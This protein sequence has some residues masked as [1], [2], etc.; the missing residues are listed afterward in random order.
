MTGEPI[1]VIKNDHTGEEVWRYEGRVLERDSTAVVLE[2]RFDRDEV[3]LGYVTIRRG[4]RFVEH[5]YTDRWYNVFA[6]HDVDDDQL[7]GF[8]CN[9]TRP[10]ILAD[11]SVR[12][13]DL[14]LDVFVFPDGRTLVTDEE[15][16]AEIPLSLDE[17]QKALAAVTDLQRRARNAAPPFDTLSP[18]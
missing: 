1:T 7:K 9:I 10:A 6:V 13:D 12:A 15:E 14:A 16:Y 3:D 11:G 8:Y 2:A 4:D 18:I 5:F 17:R